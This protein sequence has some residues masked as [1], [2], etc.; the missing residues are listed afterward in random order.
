MKDTSITERDVIEAMISYGGGFVSRLG[1]AWLRA[2]ED[3]SARLLKAFPEYCEQYAEFARLNRS[4]AS[5]SAE[6]SPSEAKS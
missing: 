2:D 1:E 4:R 6:K 3:N 5:A